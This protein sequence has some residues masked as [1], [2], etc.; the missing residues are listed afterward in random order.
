MTG[1]LVGTAM[2]PLGALLYRLGVGLPIA[3]FAFLGGGVVLAAIAV[4]AGIVALIVAI[5]TGR[6]ADRLRLY[7]GLLLGGAVVAVMLAQIET[8]RLAPPIHDLST[9]SSDPRAFDFDVSIGLRGD[10]S[11]S[12][13]YDSATLEPPTL[14][15]YPLVKAIT[16]R[17]SASESFDRTRDVLEDMGLQIVNADEAGG[18]IEAVATSFWFGF[19]DDMVARIR[20]DGSGSVIDLR[21]VSRL[22]VNDMGVNAEH[23]EEFI[24]RFNEVRS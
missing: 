10:T 2:L 16:T 5:S 4:I 23:I 15:Y 7:I 3:F 17:R 14:A 22:G 12:L 1:A 8:A 18:R 24:N 19:K 13:T 6:D 11:N 20:A 9:D 21:S